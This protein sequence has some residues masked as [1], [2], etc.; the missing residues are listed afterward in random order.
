MTN[1]RDL[2]IRPL[3]T[4]KTMKMMQD[5]NKVTFVVA[6][7]VNKT[8]VRQAIESIFNVKVESVNMMN[9]RPKKKRVGKY[10]GT[11]S[12]YKKAIVKLPEGT[13]IDLGI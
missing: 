5:D 4:E 2:I 10:V 7:G 3:I 12:A 9:V 6:K 11:T 8:Q 13:D 1:A